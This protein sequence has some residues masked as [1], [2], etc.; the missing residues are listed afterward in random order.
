MN[1]CYPEGYPPATAWFVDQLPD[2]WWGAMDTRTG[3]WCVGKD[4]LP[5]RARTEWGAEHLIVAELRWD[6]Y[7]AGRTSAGNLV[8]QFGPRVVAA[9]A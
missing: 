6:E 7:K 8:A 1:R 5:A 4:G 3:K 2:G 9:R